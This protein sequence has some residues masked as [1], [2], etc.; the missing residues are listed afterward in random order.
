MN[1]SSFND[2]FFFILKWNEFT[3]WAW[4]RTKKI[5]ETCRSIFFK[6]RF[7]LRFA[8]IVNSWSRIKYSFNMISLWFNLKW[9]FPTHFGHEIE[10][11]K[12]AQVKNLLTMIYSVLVKIDGQIKR[13]FHLNLDL[14][15]NSNLNKFFEK[16]AFE[17]LFA[18][19]KIFWILIKNI[20]QSWSKMQFFSIE[21][22][23]IW[24]FVDK[25]SAV[26]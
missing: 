8:N 10:A 11:L 20:V 4:K 25:Q 15:L 21:H 18:V 13:S 6:T 7:F 1:R 9:G 3:D 5:Q 12:R 24:W 26:L 23:M 19:N 14:N 2:D 16:I 22:L 17:I